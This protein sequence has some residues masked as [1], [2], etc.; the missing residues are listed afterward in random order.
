[1]EKWTPW[2]VKDAD[3]CIRTE[4]WWRWWASLFQHFNDSDHTVIRLTKV[5]QKPF[6][7]VHVTGQLV[8]TRWYKSVFAPGCI[9]NDTHSFSSI[10]PFCCDRR[11]FPVGQ[12]WKC[13][14]GALGVTDLLLQNLSIYLTTSAVWFCLCLYFICVGWALIACLLPL[15]YLRAGCK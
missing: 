1:M 7:A 2:S 8:L 15:G 4:R 10:R 6:A 12:I 11:L 13:W 9:N 5:I 14:T 3:I